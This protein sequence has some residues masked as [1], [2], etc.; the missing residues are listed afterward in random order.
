MPYFHSKASVHHFHHL[1]LVHLSTDY[2]FDAKGP[3]LLQENE[4]CTPASVYAK[5]KYEGEIRLL[6]QFPHACIIRTSWV[7]GK[8]G[9]N[10]VSS[11]WEKLH[12][13]EKLTVVTDQQSR[14]TYAQ[15]LAEAILSLLCH[16]G[17]YH[18]AN[19]GVVSRFEIAN[20]M[21]T[22]LQEKGTSLACREIA[23]VSKTIFQTV[24]A[25]PQFSALDTQKIERVLG[26]APRSWQEAL[27]E[28][29]D[30]EI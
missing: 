8:G 25:R 13:E 16:E 11:L 26:N 4:V 23:P 27:K 12:K 17:I 19:Q 2:V 3:T 30:A 9:K 14:L 24:A 1:R 5:T 28:Y 20:H 29:I 6:E 10:F 21:K 22:L 15:D 7:F 18:F